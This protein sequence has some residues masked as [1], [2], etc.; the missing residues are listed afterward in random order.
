MLNPL[1][2]TMSPFPLGSQ[3]TP[4]R[5]AKFFL[6]VFHILDTRP[7]L[8]FAICCDKLLPEP[9]MMLER[10]PLVSVGDPKSS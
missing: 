7:T 8:A 1:R 9:R 3:D 5:G 10:I 4:I 6:L 2:T